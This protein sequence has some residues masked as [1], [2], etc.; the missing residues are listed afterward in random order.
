MER[1]ANFYR[2]SVLDRDEFVASKYV[3]V[4]LSSSF[5]TEIFEIEFR[6]RLKFNR[7]TR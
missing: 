4:D 6:S 1:R 7:T 3:N 5:S 2:T